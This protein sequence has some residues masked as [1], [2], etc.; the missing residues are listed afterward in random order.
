MN[1]S[2]LNEVGLSISDAADWLEIDRQTL[3]EALDA[4]PLPYWVTCCL[5][6]MAKEDP[7]D[8]HYYRLGGELR[9]NTWSSKTALAS[10]PILIE[11]ARKGEVIT[12]K[13]LDEELKRRDPSRKSAGT[14]QK[15]ATPLGMIGRT[16]QHVQVHATD[17]SSALPAKYAH[18]P[19]L[20]ALVVRDR[21]RLPGKG[22]NDFLVSY[23]RLL[24]EA[25]PE[26]LMLLPRDRSAAVKRIQ[27]CVFDW[28][29]WS[30]LEKLTGS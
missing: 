20:E 15:Y 25:A 3:A 11:Q 22:I 4:D 30:P 7:E 10:I 9:D 21:E 23:L 26:D 18:L 12:Y 16:V 6:A 8:F 27:S 1:K 19:P 24:G 17:N 29:D 13:E 28:N 5:E 2:Y 14:L